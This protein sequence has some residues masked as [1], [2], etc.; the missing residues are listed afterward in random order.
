MKRYAMLRG[1]LLVCLL[2]GPFASC[3]GLSVDSGTGSE[4]NWVGGCSHERGCANGECLCG[5]CTSRCDDTENACAGDLLCVTSGSPDF[6][7]LCGD[8]PDPI[9]G[10]GLCLASCGPAS[11][12]S[13]GFHCENGVCKPQ[14]IARAAG[15]PVGAACTPQD[16]ARTTF[17]SFSATER[18]VDEHVSACASDMCLVVDFQGRVSCPY[19]QNDPASPDCFAAG[20][21]EAVSVPVE[22]QLV[23][24]PPE[25]AVY[26]S[27]RCDGP[28]GT[29]PFCA[30]PEGFE[31][32]ELIQ[33]LGLGSEQLAG[34]YCVKS[35]TWIDDPSAIPD[36]PVCDRTLDNC[37]D[38]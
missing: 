33:D 4:T 21:G 5:V 24:R 6:V 35:G 12:C 3:G 11:P 36:G 17:S 14:P 32:R 1:A 27:C 23:A 2:L 10:T 20:S 38:R 28:T 16:E 7:D 34:S 22:P 29:G 13:N 30:C 26:C 15:G 9:D 25:D 31:C 37:S 8:E 19:G 18:V